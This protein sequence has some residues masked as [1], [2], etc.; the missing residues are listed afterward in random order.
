MF[1]TIDKCHENC[2]TCKEKGDDSD[3]KCETCNMGGTKKLYDLG[4]CKDMPS[5]YFYW[6]WLYR[7]M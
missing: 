1:K 7:K 4:N 3:N 5:W 2:K 6:F